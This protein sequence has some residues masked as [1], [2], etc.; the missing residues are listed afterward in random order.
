MAA[1]ALKF[2][3]AIAIIDAIIPVTRINS[4]LLINT[5]KYFLWIY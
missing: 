4:S 5:N 2:A 3:W 1:A